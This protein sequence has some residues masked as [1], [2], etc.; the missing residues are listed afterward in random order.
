M[1]SLGCF[2]RFFTCTSPPTTGDG[3]KFVRRAIAKQRE[4]ER[5]SRRN[6]E[7]ANNDSVKMNAIRRTHHALPPDSQTLSDYFIRSSIHSEDS[8][9][10]AL[11][12]D[13]DSLFS[14][15]SNASNERAFVP[16]ESVWEQELSVVSPDTNYEDGSPYVLSKK[17]SRITEEDESSRPGTGLTASSGI[18]RTRMNF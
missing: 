11:T 3:T 7:L 6:Y 12:D 1:L 9:K 14:E 10:S 16:D 15:G 4:L 13:K 8:I 18:S 5:E 17:L 2:S